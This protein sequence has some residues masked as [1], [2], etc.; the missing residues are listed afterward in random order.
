[1]TTREE[2]LSSQEQKIACGTIAAFALLQAMVRRTPREV[3][4]NPAPKSAKLL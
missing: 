3:W 4:E 1:V 2:T